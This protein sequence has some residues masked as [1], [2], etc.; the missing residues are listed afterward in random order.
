ME[1]FELGV[2]HNIPRKRP[3]Q[4]CGRRQDQQYGKAV[5]QCREGL[6]AWSG[7]ACALGVAAIL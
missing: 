1:V 3:G 2:A 5:H 4:M 6:A 7:L